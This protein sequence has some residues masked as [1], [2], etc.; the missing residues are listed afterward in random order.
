MRFCM[1]QSQ[2]PLQENPCQ[3]DHE[4]GDGQ[5]CDVAISIP[6][7]PSVFAGAWLERRM[8]GQISKAMKGVLG[9]DLDL[10]FVPVT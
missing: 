1:N 4:A 3:G 6:V 8:Y 7:V 9:K 5:K 2:N 10:Q